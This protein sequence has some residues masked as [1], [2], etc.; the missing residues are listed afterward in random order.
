VWQTFGLS[1]RNAEADTVGALLGQVTADVRQVCDQY[2]VLTKHLLLPSA[3][4]AIAH[5]T[6]VGPPV[7]ALKTLMA[8]WAIALDDMLDHRLLSERETLA[9]LRQCHRLAGGVPVVA[10]DPY[11]K[12]LGYIVDGLSRGRSW[13]LIRGDWVR[14]FDQFLAA[15]RWEY[16]LAANPGAWLPGDH[17]RAFAEYL[18]RAKHSIALPWLLVGGLGFRWDH[19]LSTDLTQLVRLANLCGAA[20]RLA[21]DLAGAA[22]EAHEGSPN[23][24][25]IIE[26]CGIPAHPGPGCEPGSGEESY[27]ARGFVEERL[28]RV[29]NSVYA[30]GRHAPMTDAEARSS[31]V[32][33]LELGLELHHCADP[34]GGTAAL[35]GISASL[36][37]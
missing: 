18:A 35:P 30:V 1:L 12:A 21:N 9:V 26:G 33:F 4:I 6:S 32:R 37:S 11:T 7:M 13:Q 10:G 2:P 15:S 19:G 28:V 36:Q 8:L 14:S 24:V 25:R 29:L 16:R 27:A 20:M 3:I 22:R 31:F 5:D 17:R 23:L 34:R